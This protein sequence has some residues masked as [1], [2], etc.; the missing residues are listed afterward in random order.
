MKDRG[1]GRKGVREEEKKGWEREEREKGERQRGQGRRGEREEEKRGIEV[2]GNEREERGK[3][4][5]E[6]EGG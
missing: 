5:E 2:R 6:E 4:K 1:Q 3:G